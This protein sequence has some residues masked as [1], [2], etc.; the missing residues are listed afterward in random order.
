M[1]AAPSH[2][3]P[4][5]PAPLHPAEA[6][7]GHSP[8]NRPYPRRVSRARRCREDSDTCSPQSRRKSPPERRPPTYL[9]K[10]AGLGRGLSLARAPQIPA[11]QGKRREQC[12]RE[13]GRTTEKRSKPR[14]SQ[15]EARGVGRVGNAP[16]EA[17]CRTRRGLGGRAG[18]W[19]GDGG[20]EKQPHPEE[21]M[22][23]KVSFN[24]KRLTSPPKP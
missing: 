17:P 4:P 15:E 24:P 21:R 20:R 23:K 12:A 18:V 2:R 1:S 22:F 19:A 13:T 6:I 8:G 9:G 7:E 14:E 3:P 16:P 5:V 10:S 11:A